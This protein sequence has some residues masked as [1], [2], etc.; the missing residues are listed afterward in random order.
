MNQV[1]TGTG[2]GTAVAVQ[3]EQ[4]LGIMRPEHAEE[5]GV[6]SQAR[7]FH[8]IL[9]LYASGTNEVKNEKISMNHF[10]YKPEK[11]KLESLGR[12]VVVIPLTWRY[13]A[14]KFVVDPKTGKY[15]FFAYYDKKTTEFLKIQADSGSKDEE[16]RKGNS[17]GFDFLVWVPKVK[18]LMRL[19]LV[20]QTNMKI[21]PKLDGWL[22]KSVVLGSRKIEGNNGHIWQGMTVSLYEGEAM[23]RPNPAETRPACLDFASVKFETNEKEEDGETVDATDATARG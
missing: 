22:G 3:D 20:N 12:D 2:T 6:M 16:T 4:D 18:K 7:T 15:V 13:S 11:D 23:E 10:G 1:E 8:S 14:T 17:C 21:H 5:A 9:K 19:Q